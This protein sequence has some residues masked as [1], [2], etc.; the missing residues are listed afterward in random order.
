MTRLFVTYCAICL[1]LRNVLAEAPWSSFDLVS[2]ALVWWVGCYM[3]ASPEVLSL[4]SHKILNALGSTAPYVFVGC[5]LLGWASVCWPSRP[6]FLLRLTAR[7]GLTYC[8]V[9]LFIEDYARN[10]PPLS[11]FTHATLA[12]AS[13]WGLCR[14]KTRGG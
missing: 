11:V 5:G 4:G 8:V 12:V 1:R 3:V 10:P 6:P 2:G 9:L 14:T 7:M 13:A